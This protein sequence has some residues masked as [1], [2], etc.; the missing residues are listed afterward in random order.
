VQVGE[1]GEEF[2]TPAH[3]GEAKAYRDACRCVT[4]VLAEEGQLTSTIGMIEAMAT[5]GDGSTRRG[6][7]PGNSLQCH[8]PRDRK[9]G[10][11]SDS[12]RFTTTGAAVAVAP[13]KAA[14]KKTRKAGAQRSTPLTP[15]AA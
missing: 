12:G 13:A 10:A 8:H 14:T 15:S 7:S 3:A 4:E 9:K 2:S 5:K 1:P 6:D 11:E